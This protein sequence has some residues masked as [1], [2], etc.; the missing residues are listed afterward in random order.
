VNKISLNLVL[1]QDQFSS[2]VG[3]ADLLE[4]DAAA[5]VVVV[6]GLADVD[7]LEVDFFV[8]IVDVAVVVVVSECPLEGK[9]LKYLKQIRAKNGL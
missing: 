4:I 2:F 9:N 5:V 8:V 6:D 1:L 7:L 3:A